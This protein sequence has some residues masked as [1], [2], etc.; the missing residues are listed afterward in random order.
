MKLP[1]KKLKGLLS[2]V[3]LDGMNQEKNATNT[4]LTQKKRSY[5]KKHITKLKTPDGSTVEDPKTILN[6]M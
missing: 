2:G 3:E 1:C 5:E 4:F 6:D